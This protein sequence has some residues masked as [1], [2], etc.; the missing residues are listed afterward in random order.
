MVGSIF[1]Y[2]INIQLL[3]HFQYQMTF[4][5]SLIISLCFLFMLSFYEERVESCD[6]TSATVTVQKALELSKRLKEILLTKK[7]GP[8]MLI[9]V[10][11]KTI[12]DFQSLISLYLMS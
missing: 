12:P 2:L 5:V 9:V 6:D 10:L 11:I 4:V 8:F 1:G 3:K 7:V